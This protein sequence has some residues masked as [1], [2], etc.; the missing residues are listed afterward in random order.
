MTDSSNNLIK[1]SRLNKRDT[2]GVIA[3]SYPFPMEGKNDYYDWYLKGKN[4]LESMGFLL[5]ESKN[6]RKEKW[7]FAGTAEERAEDINSM[8]ADPEV[9]AIIAHD[10]GY[11]A[12]ATLEYLDYDL[13]KKNPKPL[14]GFSDITILHTAI[15]TKTAMVGFHTELLNYS[16]GRIWN[17]DKPEHKEYSKSLLQSA[18]TSAKPLGEI[19]P[20]TQ[21]TCWRSGTAE[22]KLF[23][24]ALSLVSALVGTSYFPKKDDLRGAVLFFEMD[25]APTYRL[26]RCLY[27][28]KYS[29]VL[30]VISGIIVGKLHNILPTGWEGME[31]P[32]NKEVIMD[33]LRDY[34]FPILADVDFGHESINIPMLIGVNAKI[35]AE[36][37]YFEQTDA[38]VI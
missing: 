2:I 1:G 18:L 20:L 31:H 12:I 16:L 7:W 37:L 29:G 34:T 28:L 23:G 25:D 24:G 26:Q 35:D 6:L 5:K 38:G 8:F 21:W 13:I 32:T 9:K 11:S 22:G 10:G 36:R 19:K 3:P 14:L 27:Q 30:D 4:E 15:Y 17:V 33:V